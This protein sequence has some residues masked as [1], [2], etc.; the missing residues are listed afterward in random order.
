MTKIENEAQY[1]W[2]GQRVEQLLLLVND[3]TPTD[4]PIT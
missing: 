1:A 4:D 3:N 2:A